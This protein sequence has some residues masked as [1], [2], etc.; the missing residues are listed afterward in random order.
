MGDE[1]GG[2]AL[3]FADRR[4][5]SAYSVTDAS[6]AVIARIRVRRG[7]ARFQAEDATGS[8]LCAGSTSR[9]GLSN[10]WR[11]TGPA[12]DPLLELRKSTLRA[13]ANLRLARGGD[14]I[15]EGSVWR[16][17]FQVR[18]GDR[19]VLRALPQTSVI[20]MRPY[21]YAVTRPADAL[22]LAETLA[23]VQIWRL[24]RKR[25]DASAAAAA[26]TAVIASG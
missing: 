22:T 21:E 14:M 2:T 24:L 12:G 4:L 18:D 17:D 23:V 10:L 15:V 7:G 19:I 13:R 25:D 11:A 8:T 16:R 3:V 1:L 6:G 26:S 5:D 20:S 9:W